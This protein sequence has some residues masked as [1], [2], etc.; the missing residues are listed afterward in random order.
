MPFETRLVTYMGRIK[1]T[2]QFFKLV[3]YFLTL[4]NLWSLISKVLNRFAFRKEFRK[5]K[6]KS[7]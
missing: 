5:L 7:L 3:R 2:N 1:I 4:S 6:S